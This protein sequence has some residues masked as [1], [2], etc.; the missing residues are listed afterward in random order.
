MSYIDDIPHINLLSIYLSIY[1]YIYDMLIQFND[2]FLVWY[3]NSQNIYI[4]ILI[5]NI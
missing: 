5:Y 3:F 4:Y 1:I 2:S